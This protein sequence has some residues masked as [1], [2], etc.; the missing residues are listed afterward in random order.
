MVPT[1]DFPSDWLRAQFPSLAL[2]QNDRTRIYLDNPAGTQVPRTVAD[3]IFDAVLYRN[4]NLGGY[5]PTS[6]DAGEIIAKGHAAMADFLGAEPEEVII[7]PN[8]T[9]LT[10]HFSRMIGRNLNAGDEIIVTQ[11]DHEGNV[12]PWLQ[13]ADDLKLT[14]RKLPF[15][16]ETWRIESEDLRSLI[17]D[18]TRLLA[19]NYASN[20]TGSINDVKSLVEIAREA[21][22]ITYVDAVQYAPH[23]FIDVRE[24]G[25]DFLVCSS[26]KFFGPHLG[27]LY[28]R[29][30]VLETLNPYKCRC[31]T[32]ELPYR[33]ETGTPQIELIAGLVACVEHFAA[34]GGRFNVEGERRRLIEAAFAASVSLETN[35]AGRLIDGLNG[36]KGVEIHGLVNTKDLRYRVP[37]ISFTLPDIVPADLVRELNG[38]GIFCWSGHNYAWEVV[39]QLGIDPE[40]GVVRIGI[41]NYNTAE[42][43]DR[44]LESV[45]RNIRMLRQQR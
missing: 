24:L 31:S 8:M 30:S 17:T 2:Q 20:C 34:L 43:I 42:E 22:V 33:F 9:S 12:S 28:G 16:D 11:M 21:D 6:E 14:I 15:S 7:G 37:T 3:A 18:R 19:L 44:T 26:Y 45:E 40:A 23:G 38:E 10:Y 32:N 1:S 25:C 4:A 27:I 5:F 36:I 29:K 39:Q 13:L 41:A 35:L